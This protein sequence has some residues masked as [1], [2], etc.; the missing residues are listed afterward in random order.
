MNI[1]ASEIPAFLPKQVDEFWLQE[2]DG[3]PF[4]KVSLL[5]L[6]AL[7]A[8]N[9][10]RATVRGQRLHRVLLVVPKLAAQ[11]ILDRATPIAPLDSRR[12]QQL[13]A[14][15]SQFADGLPVR[16]VDGN[17]GEDSRIR[18]N[19]DYCLNYCAGHPFVE[20]NPEEGIISIPQFTCPLPVRDRDGRLIADCTMWCEAERYAS[21]QNAELKRDGEL[22]VAIILQS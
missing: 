6:H 1:S 14:L 18:T 13:A 8:K 11:R 22:V 4:R 7:I 2:S 15:R 3:R 17:S 9:A 19:L 16:V 10:V 12:E 21:A 5:Q 20:L